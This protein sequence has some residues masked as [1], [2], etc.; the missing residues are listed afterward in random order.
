VNAVGH[1]LTG[2]GSIPESGALHG[3]LRMTEST[4]PPKR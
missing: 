2:A 3:S 4:F 1:S